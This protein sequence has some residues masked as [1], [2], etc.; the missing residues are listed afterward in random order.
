MHIT[1][2]DFDPTDHEQ[3]EALNTLTGA[4]LTGPRERT[5]IL[6]AANG[7]QIANEVLPSL[8]FGKLTTSP[9][10]SGETESIQ[11]EMD[12]EVADLEEAARQSSEA[13]EEQRVSPYGF[14][15][16][17]RE[18]GKPSP[19]KQR[20]TSAEVA[21]DKAYEERQKGAQAGQAAAAEA[22]QQGVDPR[23]DINRPHPHGV[24]QGVSEADYAPPATDQG[25]VQQSPFPSQGA[26]DLVSAAQGQ[27][28]SPFP[29]QQAPQAPQQPTA[30]P[31]GDPFNF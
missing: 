1:I 27:Q 29:P 31:Q 28:Q 6:E 19:G 9:G 11:A 2:N 30:P 20:R 7:R 18:P 16:P 23:A 15:N 5:V 25:F 14:A 8:D 13:P 22:Q 10:A 12:A 17:D 4:L 26:P 21:E 3:V 24:D